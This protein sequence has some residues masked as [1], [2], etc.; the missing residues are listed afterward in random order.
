[1]FVEI[2][3]NYQIRNSNY[4]ND[5]KWPVEGHWLELGMWMRERKREREKERERESEKKCRNKIND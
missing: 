3:I 5:K 1:M 2:Y 4:A